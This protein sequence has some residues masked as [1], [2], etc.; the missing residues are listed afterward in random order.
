[1]GLGLATL[2]D[3]TAGAS[4]A[5]ALPKFFAHLHRLKLVSEPSP[6]TAGRHLGGWLKMGL[7]GTTPA[8]G[9]TLLVGDAAGLV[10]PLQGEGISQ[11]L[12]SGRLAAQAILQG[13]GCSAAQYRARLAAEHLPYHRLAAALQAAMIGRPRAVAA[14][15]RLLIVVGRINWL[16]GGWSVFW[17]EL[18]EG[19]P[20]NSHRTIANA[21][22]W[23]GATM[24][25]RGSTARW[26]DSVVSEGSGGVPSQVAT[27]KEFPEELTSGLDGVRCRPENAGRRGAEGEHTPTAAGP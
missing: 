9:R 24:T 26:F 23:A 3:R 12:G 14:L 4:A 11:A 7:V 27:P 5:R 21:M 10:N 8:A 25:S 16:A 18:L 15:F 22:T 19:A 17:N 2:S 20:P 6:D 1:V 13:A